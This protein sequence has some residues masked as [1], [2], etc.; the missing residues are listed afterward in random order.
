MSDLCARPVLPKGI[1]KLPSVIQMLKSNK[2]FCIMVTGTEIQKGGLTALNKMNNKENLISIDQALGMQKETYLDLYARHINRF[3][4]DTVVPLQLVRKYVRAQGIYL[5]DDE[6]NKY[7]DFFNGYGCLNLG[8]NHPRI[9]N[10]IQKALEQQI[11][12]IHQLVPSSL[13]AAL[14]HN[15]AALLPG[16][17]EAFYFQNS[18][19]EAIEASIK[20]VRNYTGRKYLLAADSGFHGMTLGALS[21]T[22]LSHYRIPFGPLLPFIQHVPFGQIE[23]LA[24]ELKSKKYAAVYLEPIQGRGGINVPPADYLAKVRQLCDRY[25]TL[26]VLDEVQTGMGRTGKMFAFEHYHVVPDILIISKSLGGGVMPI[27]ACITTKK[28]WQKVYGSL[29]KFLLHSSTFSANTMACICGLATISI[30]AE[31]KTCENCTR[32]G[33]YFKVELLRLQEKYPVIAEIKGMGLMIG[34]NFDFSNRNPLN[35]LTEHLSKKISAKVV[36]AY[37]ASRLL[38]E[39]NIIVPTSL[40]DNYIIRVFPPLNVTKEEID[41]FI[42][43]FGR[44]CGSLGSYSQILK[45]TALKF[46]KKSIL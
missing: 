33:Q 12:M 31:E 44:L 23:P 1:G 26:F 4:V 24:E 17:L 10:A 2:D 35:N 37:I 21:L 29:E 25:G 36:T 46:I 5:W 20:L 13:A 14:A 43:S 16:P 39:Y 40:A 9:M 8:H 22:G 27:S 18:G 45:E 30:M 34:I 15:L 6:G 3:I 28:I 38:N 7:Y 19:S 41:Y 11:P 42:T 32:Q